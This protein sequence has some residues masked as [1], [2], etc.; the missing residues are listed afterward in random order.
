MK[1]SRRFNEIL[2]HSPRWTHTLTGRL[3]NAALAAQFSAHFSNELFK[4]PSPAPEDALRLQLSGALDMLSQDL[5]PRQKEKARQF[6]T[7]KAHQLIIEIL[8]PDPAFITDNEPLRDPSLAEVYLLAQTADTTKDRITFEALGYILHAA[9]PAFSD[10]LVQAYDKAVTSEEPIMHVL[11]QI[12]EHVDTAR[13]RPKDVAELE[14]VLALREATPPEWT[15][16]A[17]EERVRKFEETT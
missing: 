1:L 10:E 16:T 15:N 11:A 6:A 2:P 13:D 7:T 8:P 17:W 12:L 14:L 5:S 4:P 3:G 9:P